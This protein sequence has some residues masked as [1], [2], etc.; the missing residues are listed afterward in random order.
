MIAHATSQWVFQQVI[1][2]PSITNYVPFHPVRSTKP[3]HFPSDKQG[4]QA[5]RDGY[6]DQTILT[7]LADEYGM[8]EK[9]SAMLKVS[10]S[11]E[12]TMAQHD[13]EW[14]DFLVAYCDQEEASWPMPRRGKG[15]LYAWYRWSGK[16][17]L[18]PPEIERQEL[19]RCIEAL[20]GWSGRLKRGILEG[21]FPH[22]DWHAYCTIMAHLYRDRSAACQKESTG[23]LWL[24][25]IEKT[26][27]NQLLEQ[28]NMPVADAKPAPYHWIFC[29]DPRSEA[30]RR[31]LETTHRHTTAGGAGFFGVPLMVHGAGHC[32]PFI[33]PTYVAH[34]QKSTSCDRLINLLNS[35]PFTQLFLVHCLGFVFGIDLLIRTLWGEWRS[36]PVETVDTTDG[37]VPYAGLYALVQMC[38]PTQ[39]PPSV[40][41]CGHH[42]DVHANSA[43]PSSLQCGACN[44]A[45]GHLNATVSA[46][47]LNRA[48]V[49]EKLHTMGC[50]IPKTTRFYAASHSTVHDT[51]HCPDIADPQFQKDLHTAMEGAR[52]ERTPTGI[53][54]AFNPT[55]DWAHAR[56]EWG[57]AR[58]AA[59]ILAPRAR[60]EGKNLDGR[61]FLHSYH[62]Q[63]D[64]DGSLLCS[65][66]H[67]P[68]RL[69]HAMNVGYYYS[70]VAPTAVGSFSKTVL[71]PLAE[72]AF[73]IGQCSD[74]V[75][76]LPAE[77]VG[78]GEKWGHIPMRLLVVIEAP[79][80]KVATA[81]AKV[82]EE[83][84]DFGS[85][86]FFQA[87]G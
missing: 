84:L 17:Y 66:L 82:R 47:L 11:V 26:Y 58:H 74:L 67:G 40:I 24:M 76:G 12:P 8:A 6:I 9:L 49:R 59:A 34:T 1:P 65:L 57:L 33:Q 46:A 83:G 52:Q 60:T 14:I 7:A 70:T 54:P 55:K 37:P 3:T 63:E 5:L 10:K 86:C 53:A 73:C 41:L 80:E 32:P 30:I 36:H 43:M 71:A 42:A 44:G 64:R 75:R 69:M 56:P 22:S 16:E 2:L 23:Q 62:W 68:V 25:A 15:L 61:V 38:R 4:Q 35:N 29:I 72:E 50:F 28:L 87:I 78:Q 27:R 31:H 19:L 18:S 45:N 21:T 81:L 39:W 20:P 13:P 48:D 77:S 51:L 85:W 79:Q